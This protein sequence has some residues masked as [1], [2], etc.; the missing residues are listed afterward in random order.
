[1]ETLLQQNL[2]ASMREIRKAAIS[3]EIRPSAN[4][5]AGAHFCQYTY[6]V[7][8]G[9]TVTFGRMIEMRLSTALSL[10]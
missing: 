9:A 4:V 2:P 7:Y 6:E 8:N 3:M 1:M 5:K 10:T